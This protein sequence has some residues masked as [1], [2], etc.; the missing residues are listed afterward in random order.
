MLTFLTSALLG[1]ESI[2]DVGAVT[3]RFP[4]PLAI[5]MM[6]GI[7]LSSLAWSP[8]HGETGHSFDFGKYG[9]KRVKL[10]LCLSN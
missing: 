3:W 10:T 4:L 7:R 6:L 8:N 9:D 5:K 1:V 2:C